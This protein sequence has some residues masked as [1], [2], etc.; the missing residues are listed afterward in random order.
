LFF[1]QLLENNEW[2]E[3]QSL[4]LPDAQE[5]HVSLLLEVKLEE[6]AVH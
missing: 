2:E 3:V 1:W 4:E 6:L 5:S